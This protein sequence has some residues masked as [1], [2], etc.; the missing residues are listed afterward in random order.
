MVKVPED[1]NDEDIKGELEDW[2]SQFAA[3]TQSDCK[4][5]WE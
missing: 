1:W 4:Y 3:W 2:C 5:G